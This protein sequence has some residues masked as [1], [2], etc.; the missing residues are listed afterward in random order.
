MAFVGVDACRNGWVAIALDEGARPRGILVATLEELDE[1]VSEA[2]GFAVD[3]PIGLPSVG[4]RRADIEARQRLGPRRNSVF[5][6]PVRAALAAATHAEATEVSRR[7]TGH[8]IS[9]QAYALGPKI[10]EADRWASRASAPVWE[11]HPEVSFAV[12]M[13]HP[14][15]APKKTWAGARERLVALQGAGIELDDLGP[16]AALAAVDDVLDAAVA[17]WS[18]HRLAHGRGTSLPD[19][20]DHDP[21]TGRDVAIWA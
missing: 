13:G 3:I 14:A 6:T 15:T 9:Q 10:L 20:P 19:P 12:L 17:A 1:A 16:A 8:G 7:L 18:A 2:Q 11:V 5:F 4:R 21:E